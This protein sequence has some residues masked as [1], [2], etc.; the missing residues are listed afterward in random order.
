MPTDLCAQRVSVPFLPCFLP[1]S[2]NMQSAPIVL[3][4]S[5]K[6]LLI[7]INAAMII[8]CERDDEKASRKDTEAEERKKVPARGRQTLSRTLPIAMHII[9]QRE[10]KVCAAHS[11]IRRHFVAYIDSARAIHKHC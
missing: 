6:L 9:N 1:R 8:Y 5:T 11:A 3:Q 10:S 7:M 2:F 4:L